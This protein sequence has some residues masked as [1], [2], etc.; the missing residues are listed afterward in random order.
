M[1]KQFTAAA[2]MMLVEAGKVGLDDP[3][4]KYFPEARAAAW[5]D[6]TVRQLLTHT[7]G[8]PDIFGE[9]DEDSY[10]KGI[11]DFRRDY[12]EDE[13]L[14]RYLTLTLDFRP[15]DRWNYSNTG[16]EI[17]G[18]LIRRVS[19]MFYGDFLQER[20]FRPLGM[21][22]T[23]HHQRSGHHSQPRQRLSHRRRTAEE[24]GMDCAL[25]EHVGGRR[26][27]HESPR[28]RQMGRRP[29]YR[30]APDALRP[31]ARCGRRCA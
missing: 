19:G 7:S 8:I 16:Y 12:T 11:V 22:S 21:A 17:L 3:L 6:V 30:Q 27:V 26:P 14:R 31:C 24:S 1:A 29:L 2:V 13:L 23:P 15:G 25:A 28:S 4:V 9:H 10:T 18:F 20:I 5:K